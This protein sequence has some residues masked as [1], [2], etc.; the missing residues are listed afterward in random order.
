MLGRNNVYLIIEV[1]LLLWFLFHHLW[2]REL[3]KITKL[4][5]GDF[6]LR[7]QLT[8]LTGGGGPCIS[9][10]SVHIEISLIKAMSSTQETPPGSYTQRDGLSAGD[11]VISVD[12]YIEKGSMCIACSSTWD[13]WKE[14]M[15]GIKN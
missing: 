12:V 13:R 6:K 8:K 2:L 3:L 7:L 1:F 11:V 4:R 5:Y 15:Q 14:T 9:V 10:F